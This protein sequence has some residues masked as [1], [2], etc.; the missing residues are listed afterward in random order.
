MG[1]HWDCRFFFLYF[2]T[3]PSSPISSFITIFSFRRLLSHSKKIIESIHHFH[4][5]ASHERLTMVSYLPY[6]SCCY[7]FWRRHLRSDAILNGNWSNTAFFLSFFIIPSTLILWQF[8]CSIERMSRASFTLV[9]YWWWAHVE[10]WKCW[11]KTDAF[12]GRLVNKAD[13]WMVF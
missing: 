10:G 9:P 1:F 5:L 11:G 6:S 13:N 2:F 8:H 7:T 3:P 4:P 12:V